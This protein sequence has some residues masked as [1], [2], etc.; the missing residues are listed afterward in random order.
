VRPSGRALTNRYENGP[1]PIGWGPFYVAGMTDVTIR[2]QGHRAG[3]LTVAPS[4]ELTRD[5]GPVD[6]RDVTVTVRS[7]TVDGRHELAGRVQGWWW[8]AQ[9]A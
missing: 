6:E 5:N 2:V 3:L 8:T 7:L 4:G 1:Y 9:G